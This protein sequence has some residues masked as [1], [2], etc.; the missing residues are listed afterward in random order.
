M[1]NLRSEIEVVGLY[2]FF[3]VFGSIKKH[4]HELFIL[5]YHLRSNYYHFE[6]DA[7]IKLIRSIQLHR[8]IPPKNHSKILYLISLHLMC[9]SEIKTLDLAW[10]GTSKYEPSKLLYFSMQR[11]IPIS[12]CKMKHTTRYKNRNFII[13]ITKNEIYRPESNWNC[14]QSLISIFLCLF[15][16]SQTWVHGAVSKLRQI[17]TIAICY[18]FLLDVFDCSRTKPVGGT[19]FFFFGNG[20]NFHG[21]DSNTWRNCLWEMCYFLW[22]FMDQIFWGH[23]FFILLPSAKIKLFVHGKL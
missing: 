22:N 18:I 12:D 9:F 6:W 16:M 7:L 2:W 8:F 11:T 20:Q 14:F 15:S 17:W 10:F 23:E 1:Q 21:V 5:F 3:F 13:F 4:R 19:S